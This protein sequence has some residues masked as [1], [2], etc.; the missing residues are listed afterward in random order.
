MALELLIPVG[1]QLR[2][3]SRSWLTVLVKSDHGICASGI[4]AFKT[5]IERSSHTQ[6]APK[7]DGMNLWGQIGGQFALGAVVDQ[8]DVLDIGQK[9]Q[10]K[11]AQRG[12][13]WVKA[14]DHRR[15]HMDG[16]AHEA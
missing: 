16:L 8:P 1:L 13:V 9:L 15:N 11:L 14:N 12:G 4:G 10:D 3:Q 2:H 7:F 5:L 6:V